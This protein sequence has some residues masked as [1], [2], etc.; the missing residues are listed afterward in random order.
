VALDLAVKAWP[1]PVKADAERGS[2][3]YKRGNPTLKGLA[4]M[5][6]TPQG[7][8][9]PTGPV[10]PSLRGQAIQLGPTSTRA[11]GRRVM[12]PRFLAWLMGFPV[13]IWYVPS[14]TE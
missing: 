2:Q 13:E 5:W 14:E 9:K 10:R 1:T 11:S 3:V 6:R 7:G 12:N 4:E 8:A